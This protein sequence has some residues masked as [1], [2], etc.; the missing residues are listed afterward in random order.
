MG[1]IQLLKVN[2]FTFFICSFVD[3]TSKILYTYD[4]GNNM[5]NNDYIPKVGKCGLRNIGNTC[6]MNSC[7]QLLLHCK[8]LIAF[9][10]K[11]NFIFGLFP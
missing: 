6:Y 1:F 3:N 10:I 4:R 5:E 9:L 8:P 7:L 2:L 11:K